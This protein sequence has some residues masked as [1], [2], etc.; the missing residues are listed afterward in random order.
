MNRFN[1][2]E[3]AH[4]SIPSLILETVKMK[5]ICGGLGMRVERKKTSSKGIQ[6]IKRKWKESLSIGVW[7]AIIWSLFGYLSYWLNLSDYSPSHFGKRIL[8]P[9]YL[10][11][12]QGILITEIVIIFFSVVLSFLY[13]VC[14]G[15]LLTPW[16]GAA[17][18]AI[19]WYVFV[20]W[21]D[22]ALTTLTSTF[23]LF[24][25]YGIFIGYSLSMEFTSIE[26]ENENTDET[27]YD[28]N[29]VT[30]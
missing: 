19:L 25:L 18:G 21:R 30:K 29:Q 6:N 20:G 23:S 26:K 12:W 2:R 16:I 27:W 14:F 15:H 8:N 9:D 5:F 22:V 28:K 4:K 1:A 24:V 17:I 3:N 11:H 13:A 10:F 7:G